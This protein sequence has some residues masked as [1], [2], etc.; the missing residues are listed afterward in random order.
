MSDIQPEDSASNVGSSA[1]TSSA[2]KLAA[3]KVKLEYAHKR[4]RLQEERTL[5]QVRTEGELQ[6]L[7]A[8]EEVAV[9]EAEI[10]AEDERSVQGSLVRSNIAGNPSQPHQLPSQD[11]VASFDTDRDISNHM[12]PEAHSRPVRSARVSPVRQPTSGLSP[13]RHTA[14]APAAEPSRVDQHLLRIPPVNSPFE[15]HAGIPSSNSMQPTARFN[16]GP[17]AHSSRP[18][19][20]I[21]LQRPEPSL[22]SSVRDPSGDA[23][24]S[25]VDSVPQQVD[26]NTSGLAEVLE[27]INKSSKQARLP[28]ASIPVFY[29]DP[30]SFQRF[31]TTFQFAIEKNT[32]DAGSRLNLLV[33]YTSGAARSIIE[34]C[35]LYGPEQ[36]YPMALDL[37]KQN[38]GKPYNIAQSYIKG[39][40]SGKRI[41]ADDPEALLNFSR[42]LLKANTRSKL[43]ATLPI[44]TQQLTLRPLPDGCPFTS[45]RAGPT[46]HRRFRSQASN[47]SSR[48][49]SN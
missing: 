9:A 25:S 45:K 35:V 43:S 10:L 29:G 13:S 37:L 49:W 7:S 12:P 6:I 44:S 36:G 33:E 47:P 48:I 23:S 2:S 41:P 31:I 34:D 18:R 46:A 5:Q 19:T 26:F 39:L 24:H 30:R 15:C 11:P 22:V 8:E 17:Q 21:A 38:F 28:S 40:V 16:S 27:N 3:L 4:A 42:E 14:G 20:S 1:S 32:D